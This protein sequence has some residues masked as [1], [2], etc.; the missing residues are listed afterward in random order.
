[1]LILGN[2]ASGAAG[3]AVGLML[4]VTIA[5]LVAEVLFIVEL[6]L[7]LFPSLIFWLTT[8]RWPKWFLGGIKRVVEGFLKFFS[9]AVS[10]LSSP[11]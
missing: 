3:V 10:A 4:A 9:A 8:H 1:M 2:I 11:S 5:V 7:E 6:L